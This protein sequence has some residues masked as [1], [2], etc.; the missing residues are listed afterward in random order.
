MTVTEG[1]PPPVR[2]HACPPREGIRLIVG[3]AEST[4]EADRFVYSSSVVSMAVALI[5]I[6]TNKYNTTLYVGV[7]NAITTRIWEHRTK[8]NRSS[9]SGRYNLYKLVYYEAF[10]SITDAISREKVIKGKSRAW[11]EALINSMN[12]TWDDLTSTLPY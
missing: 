7:T 4:S 5:Y 1:A 10:E 3:A 8:R 11:K 6:I 2:R 12:P 9:F